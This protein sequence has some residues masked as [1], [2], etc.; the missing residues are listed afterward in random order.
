[1]SLV[2]MNQSGKARSDQLIGSVRGLICC[3]LDSF[4]S[5][6]KRLPVEESDY[7]VEWCVCNEWPRLVVPKCLQH[8]LMSDAHAGPYVGHFAMQGTFNRLAWRGTYADVYGN[9]C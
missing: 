2:V 9:V 8:E 1:M 3:T 5:K 6:F 4:G 7:G